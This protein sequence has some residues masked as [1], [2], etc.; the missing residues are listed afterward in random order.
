MQFTSEYYNPIFFQSDFKL[1]HLEQVPPNV[2]KIS[3][4]KGRSTLTGYNILLCNVLHPQSGGLSSS[5][6]CND[7]RYNFLNQILSKTVSCTF[8]NIST[9]KKM[10]ILRSLENDFYLFS[11]SLQILSFSTTAIPILRSPLCPQL[12]L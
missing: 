4:A 11:R 2:F 8:S 10:L 1:H 9:L 5:L 12:H 7:A 6:R 3:E